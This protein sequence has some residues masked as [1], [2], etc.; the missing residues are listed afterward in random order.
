[1]KKNPLIKG[2]VRKLSKRLE[3]G[4]RT[5]SK[6]LDK[7]ELSVWDV[8]HHFDEEV[9]DM[10]IY[11]EYIMTSLTQ[12]EQELRGIKYMTKSKQSKIPLRIRNMTK[13]I[14]ATEQP[15]TPVQLGDGERIITPTTPIRF[16]DKE[17]HW[18]R[19]VHNAIMKLYDE[20]KIIT[21]PLIKAELEWE[22]EK[23]L[24]IILVELEEMGRIKMLQR[25]HRWD[26]YLQSREPI[27]IGDITRYDNIA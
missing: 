16:I 22:N 20:N 27:T 25:I 19:K 6:T 8:I 14:R 4:E 21:F 24:K 11:W 10:V 5:Y 2:V 13:K 18:K 12:L 7:S 1:M 17:L 9:S 23:R 26:Y 15:T 3:I